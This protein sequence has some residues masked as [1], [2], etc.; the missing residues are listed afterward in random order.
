MDTEQFNILIDTLKSL[1]S[2]P[3]DS[4][5]SLLSTIVALV[6]VVVALCSLKLS[7]E[8]NERTEKIHFEQEY[9]NFIRLIPS[10]MNKVLILKNNF[11]ANRIPGTSHNYDSYLTKLIKDNENTKKS[12][13]V[14]IIFQET[15]DYIQFRL[16]NIQQY[17]RYYETNIAKNAIESEINKLLRHLESIDTQI[18]RKILY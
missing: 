6:S 3:L 10:Y 14:P 8:M 4:I 15:L 16:E 1:E 18:K 17:H 11:N 12:V 7:K 9:N 5:F 2:S 13:K